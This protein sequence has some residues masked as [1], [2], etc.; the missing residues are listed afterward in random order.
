MS[1]P[2]YPRRRSQRIPIGWREWVAFPEFGVPAIEAKIDTGA[3]TSA[4]HAH[5]LRVVRKGKLELARFE[6][7][8]KAGSPRPAFKVEAEV[9][10]WRQIRSSN[11]QI[12]NRPVI[13]TEVML[14][15][16]RWEIEVTL[17]S[18][19]AMGFRLLLGRTAIAGRFVVDVAR[20]RT[21]PRPQ[22]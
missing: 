9:I 12:Q 21:Q 11:G 6:I 8:P 15:T 16:E 14:G 1:K 20:S 18:R 5:R 7:H 13:L 2:R 17:T 4:L 19:D 22:L 10:D 3:R